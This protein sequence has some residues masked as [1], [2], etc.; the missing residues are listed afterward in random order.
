MNPLVRSILLRL[1]KA[2]GQYAPTCRHTMSPGNN[3]AEVLFRFFHGI[4]FARVGNNIVAA[5]VFSV[6]EYPF[7]AAFPF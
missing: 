6:G 1:I 5:F 3:R 4:V 2:H 7:S